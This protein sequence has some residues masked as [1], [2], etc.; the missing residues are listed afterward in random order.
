[1]RAPSGTNVC[2]RHRPGRMRWWRAPCAWKAIVQPGNWQNRLSEPVV[3]LS[4]MQIDVLRLLAAH[5][6]PESYVAGAA[7]LNRNCIQ[8]SCWLSKYATAD[9]ERLA[10]L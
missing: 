8:T 9:V 1:V 7:P 3:P 10:S 2:L 4:K 5:R 6:G